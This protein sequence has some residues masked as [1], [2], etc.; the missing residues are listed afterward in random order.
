[1]EKAVH[2]QIL[3]SATRLFAAKGFWGVSLPDVAEEVG[4][5]EGELVN[6]FG[7]GDKL[8]EAVLESQFSRYNVSLGAVFEGSNSPLNK[9]ELFSKAMCDFHDQ[10]PYFFPL[11]YRELL[12]PSSFFESIV[13]KNIRHVAYQSDNNIAKGIQKGMFRYGV[14]PANATMI[15]VGMF[16]YFFLANRLVGSLLPEN[17]NKEEFFS[18]ALNVFLNGVKK[19]E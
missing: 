6:L 12:N 10:A 11:F 3:D 16:H 7:S 13:L 9:V 18:Q 8:Y 15:M 5:D 4:V 14:N 19:R 17:I 2:E 1:M